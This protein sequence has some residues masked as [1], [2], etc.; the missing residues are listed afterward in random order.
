MLSLRAVSWHWHSNISI[1]GINLHLLQTMGLRTPSANL[2]VT[3]SLVVQVTLLKDGMSPR[4]NWRSR[5][6]GNSQTSRGP[7][8]RCWSLGNPR[9]GYGLGED[10]TES[11]PVEEDLEG[12]SG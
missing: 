8:G 1:N 11:S 4:G 2:Q 10:V 6:I 3:P 12:C 9:R 7:S 5:P